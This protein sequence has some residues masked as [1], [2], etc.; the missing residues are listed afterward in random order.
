VALLGYSI[1]GRYALLLAAERADLAA[2]ATLY[3]SVW[4][5]RRTSR[6]IVAGERAHQVRCPILSL[7]GGSDA[8]APRDMAARFDRPLT[9]H[10]IPHEVRIYPEGDHYFANE[11]F[12]RRYRAVE[13]ADAWRRVLAFLGRTLGDAAEAQSAEV[14]R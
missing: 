9:E 1:G 14:T 2:V 5:P 12:P 6:V 8:I 11:S 13:A 3:S 7:F 4:P 10:A